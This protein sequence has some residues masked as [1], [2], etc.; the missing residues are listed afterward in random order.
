MES[1]YANRYLN[2]NNRNLWIDLTCSRFNYVFKSVS[3]LFYRIVMYEE[4]F[5]FHPQVQCFFIQYHLEP[6]YPSIYSIL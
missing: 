2:F 5:H 3:V 6:F 1:L 4:L